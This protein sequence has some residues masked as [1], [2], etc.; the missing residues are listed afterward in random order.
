MPNKWS[1]ILDLI[2]SNMHSD[3]HSIYK[4]SFEFHAAAATTTEQRNFQRE[5]ADAEIW[6]SQL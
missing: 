3:S 4:L 5:N 6:D 1:Q 2:Q